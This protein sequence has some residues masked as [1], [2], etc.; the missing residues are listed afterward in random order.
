ME[1]GH[2]D[3]GV[4]LYAQEHFARGTSPYN[5]LKGRRA[6][7]VTPTAAAGSRPTSLGAAAP[8]AR[9]RRS[10]GRPPGPRPPP[11]PPPPPP[12]GARPN[13]LT[14]RTAASPSPAQKSIPV[15]GPISGPPPL[16]LQVLGRR[17]RDRP[18]ARPRRAAAAAAARSHTCRAAAVPAGC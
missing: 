2:R 7:S 15:T 17:G 1:A 8:R 18:D 4:L 5:S 9:R 16:R 3:I 11:R 14:N 10:G 12:P 13:P 6:R